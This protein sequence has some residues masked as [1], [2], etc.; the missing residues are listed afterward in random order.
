[1][2]L[3]FSDYIVIYLT[4]KDGGYTQLYTANR[5][6][7]SLVFCEI[8]LCTNN[9]VYARFELFEL[10]CSFLWAFVGFS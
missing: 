8:R 9:I 1:M 10:F 4:V 3:R 7:E 2:C 6:I 5:H